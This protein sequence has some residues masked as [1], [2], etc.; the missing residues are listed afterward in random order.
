MLGSDITTRSGVTREYLKNKIKSILRSTRHQGSPT[1]YRD[2]EQL[3]GR[4]QPNVAMS[5]SG[6]IIIRSSR[7]EVEISQQIEMLQQQIEMLRSSHD[8]SDAY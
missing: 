3:R 1:S 8:K 6:P 5:M 4:D 2:R 7:Q